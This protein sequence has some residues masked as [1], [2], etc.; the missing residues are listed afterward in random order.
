[1]KLENIQRPIED[2]VRASCWLGDLQVEVVLGSL[3]EHQDLD[4]IVSFAGVN[5]IEVKEDAGRSGWSAELGSDDGPMRAF[6]RADE[7]IGNCW[8]IYFQR[9]ASERAHS[10]EMIASCYRD[11]LYLA[12]R[13]R[14]RSLGLPVLRAGAFGSSCRATANLAMAIIREAEP[15]LRHLERVRFI[16]PDRTSFDVYRETL[17]RL[18][19]HS[20]VERVLH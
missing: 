18:A 20:L 7:Q 13:A 5:A 3:T 19:E 4:T 17:S 16:A 10:K 11:A 9:D 14:M 1:M 6:L 15:R 8:L 12:E 2:R